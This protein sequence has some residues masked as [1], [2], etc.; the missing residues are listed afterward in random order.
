[1]RCQQIQYINDATYENKQTFYFLLEIWKYNRALSKISLSKL[2]FKLKTRKEIV[3][4]PK[5]F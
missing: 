4:G 5:D 3:K 2:P 1:M